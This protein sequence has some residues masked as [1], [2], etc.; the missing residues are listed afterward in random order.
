M[1]W[2]EKNRHILYNIVGDQDTRVRQS[3]YRVPVGQELE[4]GY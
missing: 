2:A 1:E 4:V 3:S